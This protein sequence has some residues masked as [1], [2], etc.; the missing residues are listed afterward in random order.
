MFVEKVYPIRGTRVGYD[1]IVYPINNKNPPAF[2]G[3]ATKDLEYLDV[4]PSHPE[5]RRADR[6]C[7]VGP[8]T[9]E[10]LPSGS[11]DP[12]RTKGFKWAADV[13]VCPYI[14]P[15]K[16]GTNQSA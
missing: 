11:E 16:T 6:L 3:W 1:E 9:D 10:D 5:R 2:S 8:Q 4:S 15:P 12:Q 14:H 13:P 7:L